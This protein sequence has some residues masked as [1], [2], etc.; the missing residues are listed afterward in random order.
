[1]AAGSGID[2]VDLVGERGDEVVATGRVV[3]GGTALFRAKAGKD[4]Q[5][6]VSEWLFH[7]GGRR[8]GKERA[9]QMMMGC[10]AAQGDFQTFLF[11]QRMEATDDTA[12]GVALLGGLVV[13][14]EN[15]AAGAAGGTEECGLGQGKQVEVAERGQF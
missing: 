3:A 8:R 1:M 2:D 11:H 9:G 15:D 7:S 5:A 6:A 4:Q 10:Q 12:P 13:S 14:G